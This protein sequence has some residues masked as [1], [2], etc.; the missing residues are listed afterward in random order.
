[1]KSIE[2]L[3]Y[4]NI[5][6][7][8]TDNCLVMVCDILID[9]VAC[10]KI[11]TEDYK[12][13]F[14]SIYSISDLEP[15]QLSDYFLCEYVGCIKRTDTAGPIG[16]YSWI[17]TAEEG[18]CGFIENNEPFS[19]KCVFVDIYSIEDIDIKFKSLHE[20]QNIYFLKYKKQLEFNKIWELK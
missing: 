17:E 2:G 5:L 20:L 19:F 15:V 6:R 9:C 11:V 10:K 8:K 18:E 3:C 16:E 7:S 13:N 14:N 4:G 12:N 1:M